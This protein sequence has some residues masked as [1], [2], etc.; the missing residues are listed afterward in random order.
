MAALA[1]GFSATLHRFESDRLDQHYGNE[2]DLV[3]S[4]RHGRTTFT[5][6]YARYRAEAFDTDADK[7]WLSLDWAL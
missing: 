6:R 5:A 7:F 2:L 3:A 1:L 4:L